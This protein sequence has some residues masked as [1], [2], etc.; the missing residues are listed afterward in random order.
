MFSARL[1]LTSMK[2][3]TLLLAVLAFSGVHHTYWSQTLNGIVVNRQS[4]EPLP[5]A[6]IIEQGTV[7]GVYSDIDGRFE[8]TLTDTAS[9]IQVNLVGFES[10]QFDRYTQVPA[11]ISLSQKQ[12][13]LAEITIRPGVNPAERIIQK[14]IDNPLANK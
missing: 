3:T 13:V 9:I 8:L 2:L 11:I 6:A 10:Q 5:F 7:N 12:N 4:G 14:A 1:Y